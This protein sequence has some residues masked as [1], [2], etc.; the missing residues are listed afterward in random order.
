MDFKLKIVIDKSYLIDNNNLN[1]DDDD[2]YDDQVII[3]FAVKE[4]FIICERSLI[5]I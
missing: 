1:N 2:Q 5:V 4:Y 3:R